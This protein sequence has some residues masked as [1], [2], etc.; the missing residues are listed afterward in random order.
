MLVNGSTMT[1]LQQKFVDTVRSLIKNNE[2]PSLYQMAEALYG[3]GNNNNRNK[4]SQLIKTLTK[5][6][7]WPFE[8]MEQ[9]DERTYSSGRYYPIVKSPPLEVPALKKIIDN[10]KDE[11]EI[12]RDIVR[13]LNTL[14]LE[15][16]KKVIDA[17]KNGAYTFDEM[18]VL[19][20][21]ARLMEEIDE[22]GVTRVFDY[23][24]SRFK[25]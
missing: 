5:N 4:C 6:G 7:N 15:S 25:L 8:G 14:K 24:G 18:S 12:L 9:R 19:T 22:E 10:T 21:I 17:I 23:I 11:S 1:D 13:L 16:M 3:E 20:S 2:L